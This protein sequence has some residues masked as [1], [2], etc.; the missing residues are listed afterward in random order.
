MEIFCFPKD[1]I[2]G[3]VLLKFDTDCLVQV[4][5]TGHSVSGIF[6]TDFGDLYGVCGFKKEKLLLALKIKYLNSGLVSIDS[7]FA[8]GKKVEHCL[9]RHFV[10]GHIWHSHMPHFVLVMCHRHLFH[11]C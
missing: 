10:H 2:I 7:V 6:L 9:E 1:H 8:G 11:K 3:S 5:G 4:I